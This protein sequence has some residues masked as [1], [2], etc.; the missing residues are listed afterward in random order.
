MSGKYRINDYYVTDGAY[1]TGGE[2]FPPAIQERIERSYAALGWAVTQEEARE[3]DLP[4]GPGN[5]IGGGW[6]SLIVELDAKLAS[7]DPNY[8]IEQIKEKFGLLRF[9]ARPSFGQGS[10]WEESLRQRVI[11]NEEA[12]AKWDDFMVAIHEAEQKSGEICEVCGAP[13]SMRSDG[14]MKVR[15]DEHEHV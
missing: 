9:Y 14:W 11:Y 3:K 7:I 8:T 10:T 13:G 5:G 2:R 12:N 15:C 4:R 1:G 6:V